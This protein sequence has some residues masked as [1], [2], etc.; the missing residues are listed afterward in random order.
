MAFRSNG[1]IMLALPPFRGVTRRIIVIALCAFFGLA[2]LTI[3]SAELGGTTANLFVL[4]GALSLRRLVWEF[5]TYPFVGGGLL[6]VAFALLSFWFFGATLEDERGGRWLSEY[7]L[8]ATV[9][10]GLIAT[11][12]AMATL[13]HVPGLYAE[14]VAAGGMWPAVMALVLAFARLHPEQEIRLMFLLTVKAKHLAAIYLL[15]YLALAL[16]EGDRFGAVV[17]LGNA[18]AGYGFL[19]LAPRLGLRVAFSERWFAVRN[20]YIRAKRRR[21]AKKFTVYMKKQ[22]KDVSLDSEGR[23]V[24]PDGKAR[25]LKDKRWM[26]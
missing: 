21:A 13:G 11:L 18:L 14:R 12:V 24:D 9:G 3:Y 6:S 2:L 22:G 10:G 17:V 4:H 20:S 5:V 1:P 19:R 26:N 23:Y 7:F 8:T 16:V 15:F 25:D